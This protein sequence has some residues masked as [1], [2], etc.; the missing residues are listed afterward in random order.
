MP[1]KR[2]LLL[3]SFMLIAWDGNLSAQTVL[4]NRSLSGI[5]KTTNPADSWVLSFA[6][7]YPTFRKILS[8]NKMVDLPDVMV[9]T[10]AYLNPKLMYGLTSHINL[11]TT[12]PFKW[13]HHFSPNLIQKNIGFGDLEFGGY[14]RLLDFASGFSLLTR[15]SVVAPTG[16]NKNLKKTE[17]PLGTGVWQVI[18]GLNGC[19]PGKQWNVLYSADY[20]LRTSDAQHVDLGDQLTAALSIEKDLRSEYGRFSLESG[21]RAYNRFEDKA[22]GVHIKNSDEFALQWFNGIGYFYLSNMR[23]SFSLPYTIY[24]RTSWFTDYSVILNVEYDFNNN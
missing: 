6:G 10:E 5:Q 11:F 23:I 4:L 8:N 21:L 18:A 22:K 12:I 9:V 14:G 20:R 15:I 1:Y 13:I 7:E 24:K 19:I 3:V 16:E 2:L 17:Y